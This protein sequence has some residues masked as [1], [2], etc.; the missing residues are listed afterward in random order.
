M[1][2]LSVYPNRNVKLTLS[3]HLVIIV[4]TFDA[5]SNCCQLVEH[6]IIP[7]LQLTSSDYL[8][9]MII[10]VIY[11]NHIVKLTLTQQR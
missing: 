7:S 6:S 8:L 3:S 11:Y 9:F 10:L 2:L 1:Y 5:L 4:Y